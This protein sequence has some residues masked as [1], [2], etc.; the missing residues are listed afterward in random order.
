MTSSDVSELVEDVW[1]RDVVASLSLQE[2][3]LPD[4][5]EMGSLHIKFGS[6]ENIN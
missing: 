2:D 1:D 3:S 5:S 4:V 6:V